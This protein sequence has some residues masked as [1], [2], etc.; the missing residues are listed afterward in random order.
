MVWVNG[1][2]RVRLFRRRYPHHTT[3]AEFIIEWSALDRDA[4]A[5]DLH[6]NVDS[7]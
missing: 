3:I 1:T 5:N 2:G 7:A 4:G 6:L